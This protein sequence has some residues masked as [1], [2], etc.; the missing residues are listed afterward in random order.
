MILGIENPGVKLTIDY[1][2]MILLQSIEDPLGGDGKG[3]AQTMAAHAT[4]KFTKGKQKKVCFKCG[5]QYHLSFNCNKKKSAP[6]CYN[7]A[8]TSHF[9]KDC[10]KP[11]MN[12]EDKKEEKV[13]EKKDSTKPKTRSQGVKERVLFAFLN[14]E[15]NQS[16][17]DNWY[18]DSGAS[19]HM[20]DNLLCL[21]NVRKVSGKDV[22]IANNEKLKVE[23]IGDATIEV[24]DGDEIIKCIIKNV[25]YVPKMCTSLISVKQLTTQGLTVLFEQD[26]CKVLDEDGIALRA[27]MD[28][29]M[30]KIN[31]MASEMKVKVKKA[32]LQQSPVEKYG[33]EDFAI[34]ET[35]N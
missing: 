20:T 16:M 13:D 6:R 29:G 17:K 10:K 12:A 27:S 5:S 23:C 22:L 30:Y 35:R 18:I 32:C 2:K 25:L 24:H 33:T 9:E 31:T 4:F 26:E 21:N 11:P 1:V 19:A 34:W 8:D 28:D 3:T 7:C 15:L 14:C